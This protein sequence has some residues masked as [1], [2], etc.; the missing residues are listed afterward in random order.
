MMPC[1]LRKVLSSLSRYLIY[2]SIKLNTFLKQYYI[3][4]E[5]S[6]PHTK[7]QSGG[8]EVAR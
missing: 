2:P 3:I 4:L 6:A 1:C 8:A 7:A 5:A